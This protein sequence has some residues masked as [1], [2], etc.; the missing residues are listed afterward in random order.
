MGD[1]WMQGAAGWG[2]Q[3]EEPGNQT[4]TSETGTGNKSLHS[5]A[6]AS[7]SSAKKGATPRE[8]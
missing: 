7:P 4:G 1:G 3:G 6:S 5:S 2:R 8:N